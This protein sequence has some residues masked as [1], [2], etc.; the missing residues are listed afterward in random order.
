MTMRPTSRAL[1]LVIFLAKTLMTPPLLIRMLPIYPTLYSVRIN[2]LTASAMVT[3]AVAAK[4][5]GPKLGLL[6]LSK[7]S[8]QTLLLIGEVK[9]WL[10]CLRLVP[11]S[12]E[13]IM[14]GAPALGLTVPRS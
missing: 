3:V 13:T 8:T 9:G 7:T 11:R 12:L 1:R 4:R 6:P 5:L 2:P 14:S 10:Q